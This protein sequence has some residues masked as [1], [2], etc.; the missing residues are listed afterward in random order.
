VVTWKMAAGLLVAASLGLA[1]CSSSG[2][3]DAGG[4]SGDLKKGG[5]LRLAGPEE[6]G[7]LDPATGYG[8]AD[9]AMQHAINRGLFGYPTTKDEQQAITVAPDLATEVPTVDNGGISADGL[10]YTI[11]LRQG[12]KW[13]APDGDRDVVAGDVVLGV[14]RIC[15]PQLGSPV[16]SYFTDTIAGL[17]E[18]CDGFAKVEPT[19]EAIRDYIENN[20][21]SGV[22]APDDQ[23]VVFTLTQP[24]SDFLSLLALGSFTA[25]QPEEYLDYLPDSPEMRANTVSDGPYVISEYKP[26][27][28]FT[29]ERNPAW[30]PETDPLRK[31][32]V[33]R[34][35][36]Q[37]GQDDSAISQQIQAGTIDMQWG[38]AV[39]PT[40]EVPG[41]RASNDDR[42]VVAGGGTLLPYLTFNFLSPNNGGA[43][44]DLKVR[45]ALNYA[46]NKA[47]IIKVLGGPEV[48]EVTGQ[49]LPPVI[50]GYEEIDPY[51]TPDD[52]GDTEKAK[53]LLA[54]A[55]F[56]NG[57]TLKMLYRDDSAYPDIA[58]VLQQDLAKAGI[59][60]EMK[61]MSRNTFYQNYLQNPD[62]TKRGEWDIA[63]VGWTPDYLGNAAR[64]FF[65]PLLDG[66]K[67]AKGS[68]NYGDYN[69]DELNTV[70]DQALATT[71]PDEAAT[72]WAQADEI[73]SQDAAWVPIA[74][75]QVATLHSSRVAN[76]VYVP[77]W[78]NGDM[79][80]V[81]LND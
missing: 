21:I 46:V 55:G 68:P 61:S 73:A 14:K 41:L 49:I 25:P 69:N 65:V 47:A 40:S 30:D 9:L 52:E 16:L 35:E 66:R 7:N 39:T 48:A 29:L 62:A 43:L 11:T 31:A 18:Y 64:G 15:N 75:T 74:R 26:G 5:T 12:A 63:P 76:F 2:D 72:I 27:Q 58:T 28:S 77:G 34:I 45:Q 67:F 79:T 38:D 42:L 4:G 23:T 33:D 70:I 13:H 50:N 3:S 59:T 53:Q 56:P 22:Q 1:G 81:A 51:E 80:N 6:I 54:E 44:N 36:I 60:L 32:Y 8:P 17:T 71:D 20:D 57:I 10:T 37:A 78:H 24:A 19:V